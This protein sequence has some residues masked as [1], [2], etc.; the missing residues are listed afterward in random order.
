MARGISKLLGIELNVNFRFPYFVTSPQEFWRQ[1]HISLSTWLRDYL[2]IPLGGNRGGELV[3]LRNLMITMIL[4][5]LWHGAAW[6]FVL[7]GAYQGLALVIAREIWIWSQRH[8]VVIPE[9]WNWKRIALG[10]LMFHV[11]CYGWLIFRSRSLAQVVDLTNRIAGGFLA[12]VPE[13]PT[14]LLPVVAHR[15]AAADR[16]Y[17]S[18]ASRLRVSTAE[19]LCRQFGTRCMARSSTWCSSSAASRAR[20]LSIF[21]SREKGGRGVTPQ[22]VVGFCCVS[23]APRNSLQSASFGGGGGEG[24]GEWESPHG[25]YGVLQSAGL[26]FF[27]F[28]GYARIAT[29]GEEVRDPER[30]IPRAIVARWPARSSCTPW[31][32]SLCCSRSV[33]RRRPRRPSP[34]PTRSRQVAGTGRCPSS[35]SARRWPPQ[36]RCSPWSPGSDAP[37]WRW[38]A[39]VTCRAGWTPYTRG[40][41]CRTA[42]S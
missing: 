12:S 34:S 15:G 7:W 14:L 19:R 29:L 32:G 21:S 16:A 37:R 35:G 8:A 26:L 13:L 40:S 25:A 36:V 22:F 2:Y 23:M 3:T 18:G 27:A 31:S 24:L 38:L 10:L 30:V 28:A 11:T 1:W 20:S 6:T 39:R 42:P 5:G 33:P 4:G 17:L 41:R 9:G